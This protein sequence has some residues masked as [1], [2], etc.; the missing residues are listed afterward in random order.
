MAKNIIINKAV[1]NDNKIEFRA[2]GLYNEWF[3]FNANKENG[4]WNLIRRIGMDK[5][6]VAQKI[7]TIKEI[8]KL[9]IQNCS[10]H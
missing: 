7:L 1:S 3:S 5:F 6:P 2:L 9:A 10:K 4:Y 8:Y